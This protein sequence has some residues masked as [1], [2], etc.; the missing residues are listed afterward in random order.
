MTHRRYYLI[1]APCVPALFLLLSGCG[2]EGGPSTSDKPPIVRVVPV[3]Q[4]TVPFY[5]FFTGRTEAVETLEVR[6]RVTGY[7]DEIKFTPG[8]EVKKGQVLFKIDPRPYQ[9]ELNNAKGQVN[10]AEAHLTL[11]KAEDK[12]AQYLARTPGAISQADID[13]ATAGV[14]EAS[15]AVEAAKAKIE[16]KELDVTFTDVTSPIDGIVGRNLLTLGNL[17]NKDSTLLT[18]VVSQDPIYIN[19]DVDERTMLRVQKLMSEGKYKPVR[20]G[21]KFPI[22]F[23]LANEGDDYPHKGEIDFVNNQIDASTGTIQLRAVIDN[24]PLRKDSDARLLT[25]GL[26]VRVRVPIGEPRDSLLVPQAA[27]SADQGKKYVLV[28]NDKNVVE[29][30]P[31]L[32]GPL[33]PNGLQ[34][35]EPEKIVRTEKGVRSAAKGEAG[36]ESLKAGDKVIVGGMQRVRPGAVVEAKPP[37]SE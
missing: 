22:E 3:E 34:V 21:G 17:V 26:F 25:P 31:V 19:F 11:A 10:L 37:E 13:K 9:A 7:L 27:V 2:H 18:T 24:P 29:Y 36:E 12:R 23:G 15:A 4:K 28:V 35:V 33:Q 30:R 16:G 20:E 6:A 1:A 5:E 14:G 32:P 8:K